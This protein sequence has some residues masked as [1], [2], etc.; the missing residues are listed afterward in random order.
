[1][2]SPAKVPYRCRPELRSRHGGLGSRCSLKLAEMKFVRTEEEQLK[3]SSRTNCQLVKPGT[4][5]E[6]GKLVVWSLSSERTVLEEGSFR[7]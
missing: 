5:K 6:L 2:R 1:M 4:R 7:S 3:P